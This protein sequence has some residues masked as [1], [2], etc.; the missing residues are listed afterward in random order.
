MA[1]LSEHRLPH[2]LLL[3]GVRFLKPGSDCDIGWVFFLNVVYLVRLRREGEL[4][5][6]CHP[7]GLVGLEKADGAGALSQAL[8]DPRSSCWVRTQR[9][10]VSGALSLVIRPSLQIAKANGWRDS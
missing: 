6:R 7:Q 1:F 10:C 5:V 3:P 8:P 9:C 2:P 4:P